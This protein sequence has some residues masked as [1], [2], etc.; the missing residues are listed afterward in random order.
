METPDLSPSSEVIQP[1][2]E[3]LRRDESLRR[4]NRR[5]VYYPFAIVAVLAFSVVLTMVLYVVLAD[6]AEYIVTLSAIA[7]SIVI[8]LVIISIILTSLFLAT[9]GAVYFQARK[10]GIAPLRQTQRLFWRL[11]LLTIRIQ[12]GVA[13]F[14]PKLA[15]PFIYVRARIA[16]LK[17][18]FS[19]IRRLFSR[20]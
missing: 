7:D 18:L 3:Q 14:V 12:R 17:T 5:F 2:P 16:Y 15:Y 6:S 11:D 1:T 4:F 20:G 13:A 10:K 8:I 19:K 9:I